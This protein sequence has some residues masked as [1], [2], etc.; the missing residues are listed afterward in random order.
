MPYKSEGARTVSSHHVRSPLLNINPSCQTCHN[1]PEGSRGFHAPQEAAKILAESVDYARQGER[2][3]AE[4][5]GSSLD[6]TNVD[7]MPVEGVTPDSLAPGRT[8]P[9][10]PG[11]PNRR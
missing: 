1:V 3:V 10:V 6:R 11:T 4:R 2:L 8:G 7:I 9:T 5:Y